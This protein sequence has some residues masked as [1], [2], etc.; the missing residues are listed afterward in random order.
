MR[1]TTSASPVIITGSTLSSRSRVIA[2][3]SPVADPIH[4]AE[5]G[6][7][8]VVAEEDER[9]LTSSGGAL[10]SSKLKSLRHLT[11]SLAA[12]SGLPMWTRRSATVPSTPLPGTVVTAVSGSNCGG[13]L[14]SGRDDRR[15]KWVL[16]R[17]FQ[18]R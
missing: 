12:H 17:A 9:S 15:R 8:L 11:P 13:A 2:L 16:G 6:Q 1:Y 7:R 14:V 18:S 10:A 4:Q 3:S 5:H